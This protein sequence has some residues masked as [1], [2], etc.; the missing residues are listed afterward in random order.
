MLEIEQC[1]LRDTRL[2]N[3]PASISPFARPRISHQV[4]GKARARLCV[5][6]TIFCQC[7]QILTIVKKCKKI[8]IFG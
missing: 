4:T 5:A 3:T 6:K 7:S 2:N 8:K 1:Q